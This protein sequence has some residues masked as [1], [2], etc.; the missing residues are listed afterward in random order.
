MISI[1]P[2]SF[3]SFVQKKKAMRTINFANSAE[4]SP[5]INEE[6]IINCGQLDKLKCR[7][8]YKNPNR[9]Y[10]C[11]NLYFYEYSYIS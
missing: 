10:V 1:N 9:V 8:P 11:L 5:I 3:M 6:F 7:S 2:F 4:L